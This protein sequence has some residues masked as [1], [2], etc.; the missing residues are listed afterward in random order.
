MKLPRR[1]FSANCRGRYRASDR[2][3]DHKGAALLPQGAHY[4]VFAAGQ[5]KSA[6]L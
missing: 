1:N 2:L 5:K 6:P 4:P 3:A